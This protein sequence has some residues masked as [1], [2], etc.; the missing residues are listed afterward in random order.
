MTSLIS[1]VIGF[2]STSIVYTFCW[3]Q[4]YLSHCLFLFRLEYIETDVR[5]CTY[6]VADGSIVLDFVQKKK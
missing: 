3:F 6:K 2:G 1:S 5:Q 4:N